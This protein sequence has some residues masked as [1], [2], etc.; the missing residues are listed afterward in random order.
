[1]KTLTFVSSSDKKMNLLLQVA[2]EMGI[3]EQQ[4]DSI[5]DED[6]ALPGAKV[7]NEKLEQWLVKDDGDGGYSSTQMKTKIKKELSKRTKKY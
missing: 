3:K 1:M 2:K 6:M 7:S 4:Y 5:T